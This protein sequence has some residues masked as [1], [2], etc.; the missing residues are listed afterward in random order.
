MRLH[1]KESN[2]NTR[3]MLDRAVELME[4]LDLLYFNNRDHITSSEKELVFALD[5]FYED[6]QGV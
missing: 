1:Q 5:K 6:Y 3:D 4:Q 2:M